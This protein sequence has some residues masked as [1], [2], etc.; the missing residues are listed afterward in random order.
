MNPRDVNLNAYEQV[1]VLAEII[2]AGNVHPELIFQFIRTHGIQPDWGNV[3]LPRGL[4][5]AYAMWL[6]D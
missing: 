6:Y 2:K 4:S 1:E 5:C 3:A